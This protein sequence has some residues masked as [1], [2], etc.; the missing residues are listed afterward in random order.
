MRSAVPGL[1]DEVVEV[2][3]NLDMMF[4]TSDYMAGKR[5][6][7]L[8]LD[9]QDIEMLRAFRD[10]KE[11]RSFLQYWQYRAMPY[12]PRLRE[13]FSAVGDSASPGPPG[14]FEKTL[15][16]ARA[17]FKAC[18]AMLI[19]LS[20]DPMSREFLK[21]ANLKTTGLTTCLFLQRACL[22][23]GSNTP[24]LF[25]PESR[26]MVEIGSLIVQNPFYKKIFAFD[27]GLIEGLFVVC[28]VCR[29][30]EICEEAL[31]IL[32]AAKGRVEIISS[33]E[34]YAANSEM[35]LRKRFPAVREEK[36]YVND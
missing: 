19:T 34:T 32:K 5:L 2:L 11:V 20:A 3:V 23:D 27:I 6:L 35:I 16:L 7:E 13:V 28:V 29:K 8:R 25:E 14:H 24:D 31:R 36:V 12:I 1:K 22:G 17:W 9:E 26:D 30:K 33:A 21:L 18:K 10:F 4:I 15:A